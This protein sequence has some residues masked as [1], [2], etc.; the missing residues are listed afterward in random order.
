MSFRNEAM[1]SDTVT[2][3]NAAAA[4]DS[5]RV[6]S[7]KKGRPVLTGG[8][9]RAWLPYR[10]RRKNRQAPP[11]SSRALAGSGMTTTFSSETLSIT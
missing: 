3:G 10:R 5:E 7:G 4:R 8:P 9:L 11:A 2:H 6:T 1:W